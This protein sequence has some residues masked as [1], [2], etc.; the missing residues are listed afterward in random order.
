MNRLNAVATRMGPDLRDAIEAMPG[1]GGVALWVK[2]LDSDAPG[3]I[4]RT[5]GIHVEA[6]PRYEQYGDAERRFIVLHELLHVALAHPA[7]ER[8]MERRTEDFDA[9]LYNMACD[10]IINAALDGV[11]GVCAPDIAVTLK[12]LLTPL[13]QWGKDDR[14]AEVVR[15]YSSEALYHLLAKN[16]S[17]IDF[18]ALS[19]GA[20]FSGKD[21]AQSLKAPAM[22]SSKSD[23]DNSTEETIRAWGSRLKMARGSLAGIFNRL[24]RELPRVKTSWER[25]LRDFLFRHARRKRRPNPSRPTRRWLA[26]EGDLRQREGVDLPFERSTSAARTGRI[27]L[28][29]D[30][31][32]SIG[33][34]VLK[35]FAAEVAA[36]LERTEPLLRLIVCDADVHQ[37]YDFSGRE[38][39]KLLQG[40]KFRGGGGTD[41]RP[42][43]AEAAKW[44][45]DLLIYLTDLEG[46]AGDEPA[47]PVLWAVPEGKAEAPWGKIVELS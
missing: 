10:A 13:G 44:K 31:S 45:P 1:L 29:V 19:S 15:H 42:A 4:A 12:D 36:I 25:I 2:F 43:I 3:L 47:F 5:D 17:R 39:A 33:E 9:R 37:V 35:R 23:V 14:P 22:G 38:G 26:L 40:F 6:G 20:E 28:A 21:L 18:H 8:E 46:D 41:F 34:S 32:G 16:R 7:R 11:R 30:T 24:V 27:A